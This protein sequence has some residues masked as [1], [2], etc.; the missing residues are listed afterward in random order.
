MRQFVWYSPNLN[1]I[2]IQ[3]VANNCLMWFEDENGPSRHVSSAGEHQLLWL[4]L[5]EL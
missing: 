5:G 3:C 1:K 2:V 4:I